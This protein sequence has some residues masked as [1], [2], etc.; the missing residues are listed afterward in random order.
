[1]IQVECHAPDNAVTQVLVGVC[2]AD[3]R[4]GGLGKQVAEVVER[5]GEHTPVLVRSTEFPSNPKTAIVKQIGTLITGGGR[6]AV[7]GDSDWRAMLALPPFRAQH[8]DDPALGAW[9]K[10]S[11]PLS[12]LKSLRTILDLDR[13]RAARPDSAAAS[14]PRCRGRPGKPT[15]AASRPARPRS[16]PEPEPVARIPSRSSWARPATG[17]RRR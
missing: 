10:K 14:S 7:V 13:P 3:A 11:K 6:R 1:M 4:G 17:R 2:N 15:E 8:Q 12:H 16:E 5:A 9:L